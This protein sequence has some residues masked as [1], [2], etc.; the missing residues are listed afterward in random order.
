LARY[1]VDD[2]PDAPGLW[3]TTAQLRSLFRDRKQRRLAALSR[4]IRIDQRMPDA[5]VVLNDSGEI[6]VQRGRAPH[7]RAAQLA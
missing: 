5:A 3:E 6:L 7:A 4:N 2:R 1:A